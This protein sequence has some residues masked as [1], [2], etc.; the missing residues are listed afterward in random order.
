MDIGIILISI[1]MGNHVNFP[2]TRFY[3]YIKHSMI[4]NMLEP[5]LL[6]IKYTETV[7]PNCETI[8]VFYIST[9]FQSCSGMHSLFMDLW[10]VENDWN[11]VES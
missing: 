10:I 1:T 3:T 2:S 6:F 11:M 5:I 8:F 4:S 7:T 9:I